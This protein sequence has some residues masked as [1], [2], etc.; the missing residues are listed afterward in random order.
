QLLNP[1]SLLGPTAGT[2]RSFE[3]RVADIVLV[4]H[5]LLPEPVLRVRDGNATSSA[6]DLALLAVGAAY[7][8]AL[9]SPA[10]ADLKLVLS[11][12]ASR[13]YELGKPV[14][15]TTFEVR[16]VPVGA[17]PSG[18]ALPTRD[19]SGESGVFVNSERAEAADIICWLPG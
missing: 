19:F 9:M 6:P 2:A 8:G 7:N 11:A 14:L 1:S 18:T 16:K 12:S 15:P 5:R 17:L 4:R 13:P 3:F 10:T